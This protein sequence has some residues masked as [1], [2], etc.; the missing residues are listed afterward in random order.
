M[1]RVW[2]DDCHAHVLIWPG[3]LKGVLNTAGGAIVSYR[4]GAG[5]DG[6]ELIPPVVAT[7]S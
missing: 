1:M 5:H 3:D 7:R 4:C 6:A 2:C